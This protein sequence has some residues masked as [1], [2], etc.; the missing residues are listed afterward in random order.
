ML[1]TT[2][3]LILLLNCFLL[4]ILR[5]GCVPSM[6]CTNGTETDCMATGPAILNA[7]FEVAGQSQP[8]HRSRTVW[9]GGNADPNNRTKVAALWDSY[10]FVHA[11][12][13]EVCF[14][15]A[16]NYIGPN[17]SCQ[18]CDF[19]GATPEEACDRAPYAVPQFVGLVDTLTTVSHDGFI[20]VDEPTILLE[21][22]YFRGC[23]GSTPDVFSLERNAT[24]Q[25]LDPRFAHPNE[26]TI[27]LKDRRELARLQVFVVQSGA[28]QNTQY[29]MQ[30]YVTDPPPSASPSPSPAP[31]PKSFY[32]W[33]MPDNSVW[34]D[35]FTS[36]LRITR[37]R[38]LTGT[39]GSDPITGRFQLL[40]SK[41]V[42]PS[43][44]L[45]LK[46]F[47]PGTPALPNDIFSHADETAQRCYV[48]PTLDDGGL[49]LQSC[50]IDLGTSSRRDYLATPTL[51]NFFPED[52]NKLTW[53]AEFNANEGADFD[54]LTP[55]F[56]AVPIDA[57]L[58]IEF[59][60]ERVP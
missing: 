17:D 46:N 36:D 3:R 25:M 8:F 41:P 43:R 24:V 49:D 35:N 56:D 39:V 50:L 45:F 37:V 14:D 30:H 48:N 54:P 22:D 18:R 58:A 27:A 29:P 31:T 5:Y 1:S 52:V 6:R 33:T 7:R 19:C 28:P 40:D 23:P 20:L 47:M 9:L 16:G 13:G 15:Q 34:D 55:G 53:I 59:K 42:R 26:A 4:C 21:S 12:D 38:I 60:I 51:Q 57:M 44:I 10:A 2:T 11:F 32:Y